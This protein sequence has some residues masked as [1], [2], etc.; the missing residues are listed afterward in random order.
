MFIC[1]YRVNGNPLGDEG[2]KT[3]GKALSLHPNIVSLDVGDCNLGNDSIEV[4]SDLLP[5][6][7]AKPGMYIFSFKITSILNTLVT[8]GCYNN[9]VQEYCQAHYMQG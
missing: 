3:L 6:H 9:W 5:P 2:M 8:I 1:V 4:I 7:G